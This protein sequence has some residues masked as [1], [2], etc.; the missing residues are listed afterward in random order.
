[1]SRSSRRRAPGGP[2][3][4]GRRSRSVRRGVACERGY[5]SVLALG[6]L[7]C[8]VALLG[9]LALL[10]GGLVARSAAQSAADLA[11]IAGAQELAGAATGGEACARARDVALENGA[12]VRRC[13]VIGAHVRVETRV[14][15]VGASSRAGPVAPR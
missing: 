8:A 6:V 12:T 4:A 9:L 5:G 13:D 3:V 15:A 1:M 14:R 10:A 7:G 11:A 2:R